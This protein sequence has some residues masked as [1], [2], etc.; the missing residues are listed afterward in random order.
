MIRR[1]SKMPEPWATLI[2]IFIGIVAAVAVVLLIETSRGKLHVMSNY[3]LEIDHEYRQIRRIEYDGTHI[4]CKR[5]QT[6]GT[7]WFDKKDNP[8]AFED[9]CMRYEVSGIGNADFSSINLPV[10]NV[11]GLPKQVRK[12]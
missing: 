10:V 3:G 2:P 12:L 7:V 8:V 1:I 11:D 9:T 5:V 4:A 6:L